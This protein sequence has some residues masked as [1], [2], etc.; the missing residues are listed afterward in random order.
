M[1][2]TISLRFWQMT[3]PALVLG[4]AAAAGRE[5]PAQPLS[6]TASSQWGPGYGAARAADGIAAGA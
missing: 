3:V 2:G 4:I 1:R 5:A 6:A